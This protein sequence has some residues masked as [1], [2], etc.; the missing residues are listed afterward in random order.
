MIDVRLQE[1][2]SN[3]SCRGWSSSTR[4]SVNGQR[5]PFDPAS[6]TCLHG[7]L[8]LGPFSAEQAVTVRLEEE[9]RTLA[10]AAFDRL[11]PGTAATLVSPSNGPV[12]PGD[13]IEIA[14]PTSLL[15][16][17]APAYFFPVE[18]V[19]FDHD[20]IGSPVEP[21]P[22]GLRLQVPNLTGPA[23]VS[24]FTVPAPGLHEAT[25]TCSGPWTCLAQ[26][27]STLGPIRLDVQP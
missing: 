9:G 6:S 17:P 20:G 24:V 18:A 5:L 7:E 10:E 1:T 16:L 25:V 12:R 8:S 2:L 22:A 4:V 15:G 19:P 23:V 21:S 14:R 11:L 26:F 3:G 13:E 27:S